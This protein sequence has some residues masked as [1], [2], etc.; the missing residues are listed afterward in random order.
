MLFIECREISFIWK[1]VEFVYNEIPDGWSGPVRGEFF[2]SG[3]LGLM[4][5]YLS[6]RGVDPLCAMPVFVPKVQIIVYTCNC[7]SRELVYEIGNKQKMAELRS[8]SICLHG[9]ILVLLITRPF[10]NQF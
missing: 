10:L 7:W 2:K 5:D 3:G 4:V 9:L 6:Q 1:F 8:K